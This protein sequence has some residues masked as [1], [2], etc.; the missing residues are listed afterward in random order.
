MPDLPETAALPRR[1]L[2]RVPLAML[3]DTLLIL[4][5]F[6]ASSFLLV[7]LFG[8]TEDVS[9]PTVPVWVTRATWPVIVVL[10][11]GLFWRKNGQTLGMQA[12]RIRVT[13]LDGD[14]LSWGQVV[15]RCAGATVSF[16]CFGLGYLWP[17]WDGAGRSWHDRLSRTRLMLLP[18]PE[19]FATSGAP[20]K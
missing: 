17:L 8:A 13:S 10:F 4:P 19:S 6:M 16:A 9:Q 14:S 1:Q 11:F 7:A 20:A 5:L 2:W 18:K 3:Y 12:W 15:L